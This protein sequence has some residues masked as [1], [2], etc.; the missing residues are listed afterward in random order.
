MSDG[1]NTSGKTNID[2]DEPLDRNL[3]CGIDL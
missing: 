2:D 3:L 1:L